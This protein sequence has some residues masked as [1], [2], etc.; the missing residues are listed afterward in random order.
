MEPNFPIGN[1]SFI[2]RLVLFYGNYPV[3]PNNGS[4]ESDVSVRHPTLR[5]DL[6]KTEAYIRNAKSEFY[7]RNS[8]IARDDAKALVEELEW[9]CD[10]MLFACHFGIVYW[11]NVWVQGRHEVSLIGECLVHGFD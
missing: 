5:R 3:L 9:T 8:V 10:M 2:W 7:E 4:T 1:Q 6:E 11:E